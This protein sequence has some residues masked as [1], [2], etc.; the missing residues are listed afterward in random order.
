[1][2]TSNERRAQGASRIPF[3][4][5]VE[6]G[7]ALGPSF[8]ARALNL[9]EEGMSLRTMYL[10]EVGQ[11]I[12]CRFEA[13]G[14]AEVVAAGEVLWRE[15][16]GDG[17]EFGI[18]FTNLDVP[19]TIALQ[20]ILQMSEDGTLRGPNGRKI[21]LHIEG[22]A[23]PMRARVKSEGGANVTAFSE[24]GFLQLGKPLQLEDAMSQERRP[25]LIDR[26]EVEVE[27]ESRVP[28]LIVTLRYDDEEG[29][30]MEAGS[31]DPIVVEQTGRDAAPMHEEEDVHMDGSES[32]DGHESRERGGAPA[33]AQP[34]HHDDDE[35]DVAPMKSKL[36]RGAEKARTDAT[37]AFEKLSSRAKVTFAM[38]AAKMKKGGEE[39][40]EAPVRRMTAP[41][42]GG[43]LHASGRKV[44]RA[45]VP[46]EDELKEVLPKA[47]FKI[48]KKK[49][50]VA[51]AVGV[52]TLL[53]ILAMRKPSPDKTA[54]ATQTGDPTTIAAAKLP[55]AT[56]SATAAGGPGFP[57]DTISASGDVGDPSAKGKPGKAV[58]FTNGPVGHGNVLKLKMD[59]PIGAIQGAASPTG[60]TVTL[61]GR[62]SIDSAGPLASKDGRIAAI[63]VANENGGAELTVTFKDGVP[64]YLVKAKGDVLEMHLAKGGASGE[65]HH[66]K[67]K[68][69]HH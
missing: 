24:L 34:A 3:D 12:T 7:G 38:I 10:P 60:F 55:N 61:P 26:V 20:K 32:V 65:A 52:M 44:V 21:R 6:V 11:P 50:A 2:A 9:S 25:A 43:A 5:M 36:A 47:P 14:D 23:S 16:M 68:K 62:K 49:A 67:K 17:G 8:E 56:P 45:S 51:G 29:R 35:E 1:M 69:K 41:P 53:M 4:A 33:Q 13:G 19:S 28:Q 57:T 66:G 31:L 58:P 54:A 27:R 64:N 15:D 30:M 37:K 63:K 48:T 40:P 18:R 22:L 39:A 46:A 59:G 42:P